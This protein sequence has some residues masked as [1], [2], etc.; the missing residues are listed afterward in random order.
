M[1]TNFGKN[2]LEEN[3]KFKLIIT[4]ENDLD[5][6]TETSKTVSELAKSE[7]IKGYVFTR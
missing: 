6:L 3:K 5:G 1:T 4:N 2:L 7:N